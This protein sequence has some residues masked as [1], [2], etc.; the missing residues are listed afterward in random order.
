MAKRMTAKAKVA[1]EK[2]DIPIA[3]SKHAMTVVLPMSLYVSV[4]KRADME[5]RKPAAMVR[6]IV[7]ESFRAMTPRGGTAIL[8]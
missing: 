3:V 5:G 6:R 7:E 4:K 1:I 8:K 2:M